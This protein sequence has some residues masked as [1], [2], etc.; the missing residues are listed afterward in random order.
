MKAL[1]RGVLR[2]RTMR[3]VVA[4]L[5]TVVVVAGC[6]AADPQ[7]QE[8]SMSYEVLDEEAQPLRGVFNADSSSVRV[9][10]LASPT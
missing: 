7:D 6:G 4:R 8:R 5:F 10:M 2:A 3:Q 1:R 9:L